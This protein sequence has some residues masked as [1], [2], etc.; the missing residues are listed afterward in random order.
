V[1][2]ND[3]IVLMDAINRHVAQEDSLLEAVWLA[4]QSR[5]RAILSTTLTTVVGLLPLLLERSLQAQFLI[6]MAISLAAG[7]L[8][9]TFLTLYVVP[10]LYLARNDLKRVVVWLR[11]GEWLTLDEME[12]QDAK[13]HEEHDDQEQQ[14][15][16]STQPGLRDAA[17]PA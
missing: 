6:P 16:S 8:F 1:V 12:A 10:S 3:S 4:G 17:L 2:V 7:V 13:K 9:A 5:L 15:P 11:T 14:D